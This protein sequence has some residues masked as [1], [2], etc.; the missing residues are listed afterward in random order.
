[1]IKRFA[2]IV[3]F[4]FPFIMGKSFAQDPECSQFYANPLYLNPALAG[5]TICP[6]ANANYRNQWPGIGKSF[7]TYNVSY[8]QYVNFQEFPSR[9]AYFQFIHIASCHYCQTPGIASLQEA[10]LPLAT[11]FSSTS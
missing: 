9:H 4:A 11:L 8:D 1:M 5:V 10:H 7:I 6:K 3:L 2:I